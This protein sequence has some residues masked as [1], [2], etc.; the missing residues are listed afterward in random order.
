MVKLVDTQDL[1][2]CAER[3]VSSSLTIGIW[4]AMFLVLAVDS[5]GIAIYTPLYDKE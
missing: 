1:G 2:S 4:L 5:L 3:R